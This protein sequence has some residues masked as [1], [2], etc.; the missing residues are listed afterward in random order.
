MALHREVGP[1]SI[2]CLPVESP[3]SSFK[4]VER[5]FSGR[6]S[7]RRLFSLA[8]SFGMQTLV[9]ERIPARGIIRDENDEIRTYVSDYRMRSLVRLSFWKT[10][11]DRPKGLKSCQSRHLIGYA[12]LKHDIAPSRSV[13]EWH[14]FESVFRK[15]PHKHNCVPNP[16]NHVL[17]VGECDF[18]I[19]GVLYCQQNGLNKTCAH[20]ALRSL[21]SRRPG[22]EDISY[23]K[24]NELAASV[25]KG[26]SFDPSAG[27]TVQQISAVLR[28]FGVLFFAID[29][30]EDPGAREDLPYQKFLYAGVESGAGALLG[31]H[32]SGPSVAGNDEGHIIPF[33]GHT[34]NKD[35]WAPDADV[36]YFNVGRDF[37]YFPS[38]SWTSSFLGHDDNFGPNF[39]VPRL[40]IKSE[41]ADYV[42]ELLN[43]GVTYSGAYAEVV[44]LRFLYS[45]LPKFQNSSNEWL[46]RLAEW[47]H[48]DRQQVV[49]RAL[50]L[51]KERFVTHL[52][53]NQD[54]KGNQENPVVTDLLR[55]F[56]PTNLWVVEISLPHLFPA[57]ERKLGDIVLDASVPVNPKNLVDFRKF[58]VAR[59]PGKYAF[60]SSVVR[61][62]PRFLNIP[63]RIVSHMPVMK[64]G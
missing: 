2:K 64:C 55:K 9:V 38:G 60:V 24:I 62:K 15:Y 33:Y 7:V 45:L 34:F 14:V 28:G 10:K 41:Q 3:F 30:R 56:L 42:V 51:P 44:S 11:F 32:L 6:A 4:F 43:E 1:T 35:T 26:S 37:G 19:P 13:D 29:Y 8:R 47:A 49:L 20:V 39:C 22:T 58:V 59:V 17:A 18:S 57:N 52:E 31:F 16:S 21:L 23:K 36:S 48:P 53:A 5:R 27:L 12:I 54:W 46:K 40:Y 50:S 61:G 25:S 63:S